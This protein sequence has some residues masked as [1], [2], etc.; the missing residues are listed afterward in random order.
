MQVK[1]WIQLLRT[2]SDSLKLAIS[3][4]LIFWIGASF[5]LSKFPIGTELSILIIVAVCPLLAFL[6]FA[7]AAIELG[8]RAKWVQ[9]C[10]AIAISLLVLLLSFSLHVIEF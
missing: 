4:S 2:L 7:Y 6:T 1:K 10:L 8:K 5:S 9:P 3:N